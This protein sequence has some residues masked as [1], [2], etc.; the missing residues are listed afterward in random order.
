MLPLLLVS[1]TFDSL[2]GLCR[3]LEDSG[4]ERKE[5]STA[6]VFIF[7]SAISDI[8]V[9]L[10]PSQLLQP[11][12]GLRVA[13]HYAYDLWG[14]MRVRFGGRKSKANPRCSLCSIIGFV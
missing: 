7:F 1:L 12:A 8:L 11:T 6:V 5:G 9:R 13:S 10:L 2:A 4:L 3:N 14:R